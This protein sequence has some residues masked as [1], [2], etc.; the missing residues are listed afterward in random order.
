M[1][2]PTIGIASRLA[3]IAQIRRQLSQRGSAIHDLRSI[4]LAE[5]AEI[6]LRM[7]VCHSMWQ[8]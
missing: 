4:E 6:V 5:L 3:A 1:A 7:R 2:Q 8:L